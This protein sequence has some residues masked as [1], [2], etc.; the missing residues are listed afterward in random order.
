MEMP[1]WKP[2]QIDRLK[3][4]WNYMT[5]SQIG[6][7]LGKSRSAICGKAHRLGLAGNGKHLE[8]D[9]HLHPTPRPHKAPIIVIKPKPKPKP[10][11][12]STDPCPL[13]ELDDTRC[14]WPL[15][16]LLEPA[17]M[18]CGAQAV[19]GRPYCADHCR[20][21][22]HSTREIAHHGRTH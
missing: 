18:F 19:D 22:Y 5:A 8:I 12:V 10:P 11:P 16:E 6:K 9:P 4:V 20:M 7:E 17:E 13:L 2:D 3:R 21:A 15:G 14:H 1:Q